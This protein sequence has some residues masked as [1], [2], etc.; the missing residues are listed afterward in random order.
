MQRMPS[1]CYQLGHRVGQAWAAQIHVKFDEI[2]CSVCKATKE[3]IWKIMMGQCG[4][5][6]AY[7]V[8][9]LAFA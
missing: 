2:V 3:L 8:Q 4:P 1:T 5:S 7:T 6:A 9:M